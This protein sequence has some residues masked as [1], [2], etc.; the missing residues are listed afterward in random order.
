MR[1]VSWGTCA[2]AAVVAAA[3]GAQAQTSAPIQASDV[4]QRKK[5]APLPPRGTYVPPKTSWGDPAIAGAYNNS[6]ESGIPFE[7]PAEYAG[8]TL[9]SFTPEE[10]AKITRQRQEQ[11]IERNPTLSE[12]PGA[13][14]PMHWFENYFAANSRAWLVSDPPDGK[15]PELTDEARQRA[16]AREEARK[17]RGPADS[18]TDRSLYDRC[19]TRGVPGSM[20]PAI[21]GNSYQIMQ[22]PDAVTITYE[23]IHDTRV[24]PL[25]GRPHVAPAIRQYLGDARGHWE[26]NTLVVETTNFND[27]VPFRGSSQELKL[28]ERFTPLGPDTLEWS[29]TFDDP[30]TWARPWT[31]AMNLTHDESQPLFEYACHEG[32]YGLRNMLSAARAEEAAAQKKGK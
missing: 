18:Y 14:S 17:G 10:L 28:I 1:R 6:D 30:H 12:F 31:F 9:D 32:N 21:Y 2:A 11:T 15:V 20:M 24:I 22:S 13:T 23:M 16:A 7:R 27:R 5:V 29:V 4:P 8:R 26:G 25:D 3:L 19:I